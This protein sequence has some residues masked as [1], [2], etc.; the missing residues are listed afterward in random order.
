MCAPSPIPGAPAG[1]GAGPRPA[2]APPVAA[3]TPTSRPLKL[4]YHG[5]PASALAVTVEVT[6]LA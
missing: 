2:S 1:D 6:R 5:A 3:T 4:T